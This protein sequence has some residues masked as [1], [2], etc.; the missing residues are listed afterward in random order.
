MEG[1]AGPVQEVRRHRRVR[2]RDR[3]ERRRE[4]CRGDRRAG[5][6]LR[7]HQPRGHQGARVLRGWRSGSRPAWAS[8]SSTDDQ[9]GTAIIVGAAVTN[10]LALSGKKI[11]EDQGGSPRAPARPRLACPSTCSSRSASSART[12]GSRTSRGRRLRG[13]RKSSWTAGKAAY[14]AEEPHKAHARGGDRGAPTSSSASRRP[15]CS[16][17]STSPAM[18]ELPLIMALANPNP[19][20]MPDLAQAV[21]PDAM[22]CNRAL[23]LP[24]PGQTTSCA[25][26]TSSVEGGRSTSAPPRSTRR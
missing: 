11:D 20:I 12:S 25:S 14:A 13:P 7:R 3:A 18:A 1:K 22:I 15:A 21:R 5:A 4:A 24:Q 17:P 10:A 16:S 23:G 2:H 26:P 9:H 19:E 8:P 6:D